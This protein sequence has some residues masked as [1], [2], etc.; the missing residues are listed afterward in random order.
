MI[1]ERPF[2]GTGMYGY[3]ENNLSKKYDITAYD[4]TDM[5]ITGTLMQYGIIG[6]LI[7]YLYY[8]KYYM[9]IRKLYLMIKRKG[10][11][12]I[13]KVFYY[14]FIISL[15]IISLSMSGLISIYGITG[16]LVSGS[17]I[18]FI[19]AGIILACLERISKAE[20]IKPDYVIPVN[21]TDEKN[22]QTL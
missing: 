2:F 17:F 11:K 20:F 15:T 21:I 9:I 4:A 22:Y 3:K 18:P 13:L 12:E 16:E 1:K 7:Y 6:I 5:S 19:Y 10:R 14:E 8:V